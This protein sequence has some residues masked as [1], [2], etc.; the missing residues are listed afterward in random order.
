MGVTQSYSSVYVCAFNLVYKLLYK[1][2]E[3]FFGKLCTTS[4]IE[5]DACNIL[6]VLV[7]CDGVDSF[8]TFS[9]ILQDQVA[10]SRVEFGTKIHHLSRTHQRLLTTSDNRRPECHISSIG[11]HEDME[12]FPKKQS[13]RHLLGY[14]K[15]KDIYLDILLFTLLN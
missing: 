12:V 8:V 13:L 4:N 1:M 10:R 2:C 6:W 5:C 3:Q 14:K 7:R 11:R 9:N 15:H